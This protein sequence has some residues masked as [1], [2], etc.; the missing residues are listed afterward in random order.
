MAYLCGTVIIK[1]KM[2]HSNFLLFFKELKLLNA[3]NVE[4]KA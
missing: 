2:S 3:C 4:K 1:A